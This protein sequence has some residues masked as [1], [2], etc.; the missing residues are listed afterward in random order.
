MCPNRPQRDGRVFLFLVFQNG[1]ESHPLQR[2]W[3]QKKCTKQKDPC[4]KKPFPQKKK[5]KEPTSSISSWGPEARKPYWWFLNFVFEVNTF[6]YSRPRHSPRLPRPPF[7]WRT[8]FVSRWEVRQFLSVCAGGS[9]FDSKAHFCKI[10]WTIF[11][12][13][14]F[15]IFYLRLVKS[16]IFLFARTCG[17]L[18]ALSRVFTSARTKE[19]KAFASLFTWW[20]IRSQCRVSVLNAF[21]TRFLHVVGGFVLWFLKNSVSLLA[22]W[23]RTTYAPS[24]HTHISW[25]LYFLSDNN[26]KWCDFWCLEKR[27]YTRFEFLWSEF[28]CE[29]DFPRPN[30]C[31]KYRYV[32]MLL[33]GFARVCFN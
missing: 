26:H 9:F 6:L 20:Y 17:A 30:S 5:K 2:P 8:I 10:I 14:F 12:V 16:P 13:L 27:L 32:W 19:T 23:V 3:C 18:E 22:P 1:N 7:Y 4:T 29:R 33:I 24:L 21:L 25:H 11:V 15:C 28:G 31:M